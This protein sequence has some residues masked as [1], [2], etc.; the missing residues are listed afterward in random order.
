MNRVKG[1]R[2][3][4]IYYLPEAILPL[5]FILFFTGCATMSE[6]RAKTEQAQQ[7]RQKLEE[8]AERLELKEADLQTEIQNLKLEVEGF[9]RKESVL[10]MEIERLRDEK[11]GLEAKITS[12]RKHQK[13]LEAELVQAD[14]RLAELIEKKKQKSAELIKI[15]R[16]V[17]SGLKKYGGVSFD[18]SGDAVIVIL[19]N[20]LALNSGKV[21]IR[22]S[23]LPLL[24]E[25][26]KILKK[27][28]GN[29][30]KIS[31]HTDDVPIK[32]SH[33]SN[34]ELSMERALAILHYLE[35][36]GIDPARMSAAGCGE[37]MPRAANTTPQ[38]RAKNR[39]VEIQILQRK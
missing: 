19:E 29:E 22:K 18:E 23:A 34:W 38:G 24:K 15:M 30:L 7:E 13:K 32:V 26:S 2:R 39:R 3:N 31:G 11:A 10:C 12:S 17:S 35:G 20:A 8:T 1:L 27:F 4:N 28:P 36:Q 37:Y 14:R 5:C 33:K 25:L 6:F 16:Q 21:S 9:K